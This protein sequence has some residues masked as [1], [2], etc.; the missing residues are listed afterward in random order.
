MPTR[1]RA[2]GC[3]TFV[4]FAAVLV[5]IAAA[6]VPQVGAGLR[7]PLYAARL[8]AME[9]L[10]TTPVPVAGVAPAAL[11][12]TW[13]GARSGGRSHEGIDIFAARGTPVVSATEG[14]VA[15]VGTNNLGGNVVWV[16]GPG[17]EAHYY[18]HLEAP[19]PGLASGDR[20]APGDTL[21]T[22]GTSGN[23]AG[24]PPHLHY[25]IYTASG[26]TNPYP[27]LAVE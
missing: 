4:F 23:A 20:V 3:L 14:I 16:Q 18:A 7:A 12:D 19:Q 2:S 8:A 25:G 17:R 9:P 24:T 10:A 22:V 6:L 13:G 11:T 27:R 26:A 5:L 21:G 1:R 15:K